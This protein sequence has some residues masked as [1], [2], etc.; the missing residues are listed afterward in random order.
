MFDI[1]G[2]EREF[3]FFHPHSLEKISENEFLLFDNDYH[4]QTNLIN[5]QSRFIC[6][7]IDEDSMTA[8]ITREWIGPEEY[9]SHVWGDCDLLPNNN[10][11]G[12]FGYTQIRGL[13]TGSKFVEVNG[14][15][16]IVWLLE[17]PLEQEIKYTTYRVERVRFTP[18]VS[19]P[20]FTSS[21]NIS[22]FEWDVWYN[23]K[24]RTSFEGEYYIYLDDQL[25]ED[26][27]ITFPK[28]WH[29]TQVNYTIEGLDEGKHEI[30]LIVSDGEGHLSNE[31]EFYTGEFK[32]RI[33]QNY[34]AVTLGVSLGIGIPIIATSVIFVRKTKLKNSLKQ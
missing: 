13:E 21:G 34:L 25:V 4:N 16:E 5:R 15:G 8:N 12:V 27:N 20:A 2:R 19:T 23:F 1:N 6:I 29:P 17:S 7:T 9:F 10:W 26:G 32:F 18:I 22:H 14:E 3:L 33:G 28:Y 24:A 30:T 31:S 11:F